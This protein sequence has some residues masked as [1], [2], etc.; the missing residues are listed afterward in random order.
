MG[1]LT[2]KAPDNSAQIAELKAQQDQAE[3]AATAEKQS[4]NAELLRLRQRRYG[5][6]SLIKNQGGELGVGSVLGTS[7]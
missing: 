6:L 3:A 4:R 5:R 2:P 1:A 7:D